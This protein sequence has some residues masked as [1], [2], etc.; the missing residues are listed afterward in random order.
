ML[1]HISLLVY[2][3]VS[4]HLCVYPSF[5]FLHSPPPPPTLLPPFLF[6]QLFLLHH[7]QNRLYSHSFSYIPPH[8]P[9][10]THLSQLP[11]TPPPTPSPTHHHTPPPPPTQH[12]PRP[13]ARAPPERRG[14]EGAGVE[15]DSRWERGVGK[16]AERLSRW[17][18][19]RGGGRGGGG[20]GGWW[21]G[22]GGG[23]GGNKRSK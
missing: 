1:V 14:G 23:G 13:R 16:V 11:P 20:W 18:V 15:R 7:P 10:D 17:V 22:G 4:L 6:F 5:P 12:Q 21:G 3:S 2:S 8:S 19:M 9:P